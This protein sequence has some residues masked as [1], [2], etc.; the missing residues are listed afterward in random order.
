MEYRSI[1]HIDK[2]R[3]ENI[4]ISI[5]IP[6][7]SDNIYLVCMAIYYVAHMVTHVWHENLAI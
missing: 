2:S 1:V 6:Y 4:E 7:M 5:L 3:I